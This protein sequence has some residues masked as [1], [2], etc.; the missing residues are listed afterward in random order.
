MIG[1]Q[2]VI[3]VPLPSGNVWRDRLVGTLAHSTTGRCGEGPGA[4]ERV[5]LGVKRCGNSL[6][7]GKNTGKSR[8][9]RLTRIVRYVI[10]QEIQWFA[11]K[12]P[13]ETRTGNFLGETGR[14][15]KRIGLNREFASEVRYRDDLILK[16]L[17]KFGFVLPS[18]YQK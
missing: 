11:Q 6:R 18:H 12:I 5:G 7:T 1:M 2:K 8:Q 16:S 17:K 13:Y 15:Q 3:S 9:W 10:N 14:K 4:G